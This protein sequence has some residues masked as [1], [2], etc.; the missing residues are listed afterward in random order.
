MNCG[1]NDAVLHHET[2]EL[3]VTVVEFCA[4]F[5]HML[6]KKNPARPPLKNKIVTKLKRLITDGGKLDGSSHL[7]P[8]TRAA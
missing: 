5:R 6:F 8:R 1:Q 7:T 2:N 3:D 4:L